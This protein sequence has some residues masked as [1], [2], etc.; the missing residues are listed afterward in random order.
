MRDRPFLQFL[1]LAVVAF[2]IGSVS[3][4]IFEATNLDRLVLGSANYGTDPNP[5]ADITLQNDEYISNAVNGQIDFGAANLTT[6]GTLSGAAGTVTGLQSFDSLS[7]AGIFK[8]GGAVSNGTST[9][10]LKG[11]SGR[12]YLYKFFSPFGTARGTV[13][14]SGNLAGFADLGAT[15]VT[16]SGLGTVGTLKV[17]AGITLVKMFLT[18][19]SDSLGFIVGADTLYAS[20]P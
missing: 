16:A 9:G 4:P 6:T 2:T 17:G 7:V 1:I 11:L 20:K 14:T 8:Q 18:A 3:G 10:Y 5:T 15:T 19:G 13:D 12:A